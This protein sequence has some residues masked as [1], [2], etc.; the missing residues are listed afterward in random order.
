MGKLGGFKEFD[1]K[2]FATRPVKERVKDYEEVHTPLS[3]RNMEEQAARCMN[4][5]TPFCNWGC[6]VGNLIPDWNDFSYNDDWEKAYKRL[7]LTNNF[8]EFTGRICPALCEASCTLGINYNPVSIREIEYMIIEKAF[9]EGWVKPNPPKNR[10]GKKVA[11]VGSG[12]SGLAAA[13]Q[14]NSV[15]HSV[16]VF[17]RHDEIGGLL[18][19]GIPDFKLEKAVVQRRVDLMK[20]EGIEFKTNI[21]VGVNINYKDLLNEFD[22]VVL[23]GGST[24]P[25]DLKAPG[26][27]LDGI[28]FAVDY[29]SLQNK[30]NSNKKIDSDI[31]AKGKSVVVIGGGDTGSDCIG[32]AIR[33]GAKKVCQIE[34]MPKPPVN[35]DKTMPWPTYP[36]TLKTTTSHEEGCERKWNIST[37]EF[38]GK[39]GS[40]KKLHCTEVKWYKDDNGVM[41][42]NELKGSEFDIDADLVLI[43]MGFLHPQHEGLLDDLSLE[44]DKR[45]NVITSKENMTSVKGVFSA[46]DMRTGQSLVVKAIHD[47]RTTAKYVD[48]YLMG[49]T[50][51]K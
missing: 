22:A 28:Y 14:L 34:I 33:Q 12:P 51:L 30:K 27:E 39:D 16:V 43:A 19:Y 25:R 32:T 7:S 15:G 5:G 42:F 1:R 21:N 24:M 36:R 35:R 4:C 26:R 41:K 31:T 48:K 40:V 18:R 6:P 9:K 3:L 2:D 23:A 50:F 29:L 20:Q 44:Y 37:K 13:A 45:G 17:E 11:V 49:D 46:G 47:G 8:P 38:I 10:T